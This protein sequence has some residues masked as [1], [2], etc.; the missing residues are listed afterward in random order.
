MSMKRFQ[1]RHR[2]EF[3]L[4]SVKKGQRLF[5][6]DITFLLGLKDQQQIQ[7]MFETARAL[8]TRHFGNKIFL[9]GF[10]YIST[11]CRNNCKFC[12]FR[13]SNTFSLRY[14]KKPAEIIEASCRLAD[15]GVH[16]IDLTMGEDPKFFFHGRSAFDELTSLVSSVRSIT[17]LPVMISPGV[18]PDPVLED[19]AA[20]GA[21]WYACY[22]ETHQLAL[23]KK[24]RIGQSY[25][26]RL[27]KK[28]FAHRIGML[29]EEGLLC[30]IGETNEDVA[31]SIEVIRSLDADQI[32]VMNFVP[33]KG[34][35][36]E[37]WVPPEPTRELMIIAIMRLA[38]PD[39]LIPASLDVEGLAGLKPRLEAG[40][41]VV[42][43]LVPP[44]QG[45]A[46]VAQS[47]LDIEDARR[48][49]DSVQSVLSSCGLQ[50]ASLDDYLDWI[51]NRRREVLRKSTERKVIC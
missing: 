31:E 30:G 19:F 44:G 21:T 40:A 26:E 51:A 41:N 25:W 42:T 11:F 29:I 47:C 22:Q 3:I 38:F 36:M 6:D 50:A 8:R 23:F 9:Y 37:G 39:R 48:T 45:L 1:S 14:R 13:R 49:P 28:Y 46:G 16:L 7:T 18:V 20:G 32:R 33:Q 17:G 27:G 15:S 12:F 35:P 10:V 24:L 5:K 34:T 43:S 2:F 4:N